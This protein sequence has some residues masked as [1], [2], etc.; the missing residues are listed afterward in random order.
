MNRKRWGTDRK[1]THGICPKSKFINIQNL[2]W[3]WDQVQFTICGITFKLA[4]VVKMRMR[5]VSPESRY[6]IFSLERSIFCASFRPISILPEPSFIPSR[7]RHFR[8]DLL[9][10]ASSDTLRGR[11]DCKNDLKRMSRRVKKSQFFHFFYQSMLKI[12]SVK[13]IIM[14][15]ISC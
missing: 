14:N 8:I 12:L 4:S 11:L 6:K 5:W 13:I 3:Q 15:L 7:W 1:W 2:K 9:R 10:L